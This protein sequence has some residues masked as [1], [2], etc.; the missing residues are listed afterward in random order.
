MTFE[1][2]GPIRPGKL[3]RQHDTKA[4]WP[5]W[6]SLFITY[7]IIRCLSFRVENVYLDTVRNKIYDYCWHPAFN[8]TEFTHTLSC[9]RSIAHR[10]CAI[11]NRQLTL[12]LLR[13][14]LGI[15]KWR[16]SF[17]YHFNYGSNKTRALCCYLDIFLRYRMAI[18]YHWTI[19]KL[20]KFTF[21]GNW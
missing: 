3:K 20:S 17:L 8:D 13:F 5:H 9:W 10:N 14:A 16:G 15:A 2:I 6:Y 12:F 1:A 21:K 7:E 11:E 18:S 4:T 19:V